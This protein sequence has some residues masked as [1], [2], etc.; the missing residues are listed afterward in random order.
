MRKLRIGW[1]FLLLWICILA[2]NH[3]RAESF[4]STRYTNLPFASETL[5]PW[6][7]DASDS[8]NRNGNGNGSGN[9]N[10]NG[11]GSVIRFRRIQLSGSPNNSPSVRNDSAKN[12]TATSNQSFDHDGSKSTG[13]N[14]FSRNERWLEEATARTLDPSRTPLGSLTEHDVVSITKLMTAWSRRKSVEAALQVELLL[15]RIVDDLKAGNMDVYVSTKIYT[16]AIEAWGKSDQAAGAE[17]AQSI[18]D[19]LVRTYQQTGDKRLRPTAKSYNTLLLAWAKS[20]SK[21]K[22]SIPSTNAVRGAERVLN[23]ML[24]SE[25]SVRPDSVTVSILLNLYARNGSVAKA[26]TLV[27][28][29]GALGVPKTGYV[30]TALQEVYVRSSRRD[31]PER[32]MEVLRE[33]LLAADNNSNNSN[34]NNNNRFRPRIANY[35][36]VL[37]AYSRTPSKQSALLAVEMV[38]R[39]EA[40]TRDGGYDV[41]PDRLTYFLAILTCSRCPNSTFGAN[42]AEP[43]LERMEE[44]SLAE[45]KRREEL[46]IAAPVRISMDIECFNVVLTA[47][48][49][50]RDENAVERIF[51]ILERMKNYADNGQQKQQQE[52]LRPTTRSFN[53]ALNALSCQK[54][55]DAARRAEDTLTLMFRSYRD[56]GAASKPDAFSYTALLRCYQGLATAEAAQRG[57]DVLSRMEELFEAD[58]LDE[59]PDT[60]HY[61]IVCSTWSL[62]RSKQAPQKCIELLARMKQKDRDGWPRVKPNIRTYNAVLDCLSRSL[63][64]NRAEEL[65]YHMLSLARN[66]DDGARPDPFSFNA[67]INAFL[68]SKLRDSGRRAESVLERAL[69]Y[70]EEDGGAMPEIKSFTAILGFYSRQKGM[71]SPYRARYLLNRLIS[72]FEAGHTHLSPHVSCFTSVMESYASQRNRDAGEC[73]EEMLRTMIQ[74]QK[75]YNNATHLEVNTGV[76]NC[77]LHAWAESI[78]NDEAAVRAERLV[79]LMETKSD[80]GDAGMVPNHRSY[81]MVLKAWSKS[82]HSD[83]AERALAV[84]EKAKSR[85]EQGKLADPPPEYAYSL[86]LQACAF[87]RHADP[88]AEARAYRIAFGAMKELLSSRKDQQ[89]SSGTYAW[90]LQVCSRLQQLSEDERRDDLKLVVSKCCQHGRVNEFVLQS[91]KQASSEALFRELMEECRCTGAFDDGSGN[92]NNWKERIQLSHLPEHW[93]AKERRVRTKRRR[94]ARRN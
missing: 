31:A 10:G 37:C 16:V 39:I 81:N 85:H 15:K 71:D 43:L 52:H 9:R 26:E 79:D 75:N 53:T 21:S 84:L 2:H 88:N 72:L 94:N 58:L 47:L 74:L 20:K 59:P 3:H 56:D 24:A 30:Y 36:N 42:Q 54:T 78:G 76:V 32:T 87:S 40:A 27:D 65:L 11:N 4:L 70:A 12:T 46:S 51:A 41:E 63:Q 38:N 64:A 8:D 66:G 48:S 6:P 50:S 61:T 83:K 91:I 55:T 67:V 23:S 5:I 29:T 62:S 44:R 34:N 28:S 19:T 7:K 80:E 49:K 25:S 35:N 22:S 69:E 90:F 68:Y 14:R 1:S 45:A 60:Y 86:V 77:V 17:R 82:N 73:S 89:P 57:H 92:E 13:N 33:M 93:V 18:H